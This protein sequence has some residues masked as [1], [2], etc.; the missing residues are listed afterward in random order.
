[1]ASLGIGK[2]GP[3]SICRPTPRWYFSGTVVLPGGTTVIPPPPA[4]WLLLGGSGPV[5]LAGAAA[6]G[7]DP[8]LIED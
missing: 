1:L 3:T 6:A 2:T 4:A 5:R 8:G 7:C